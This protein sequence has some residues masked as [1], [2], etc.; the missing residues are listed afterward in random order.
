MVRANGGF[1]DRG[2]L[3]IANE[4]GPELVGRIG[5]QSAVANQNQIIEGI[6][7]GV[8]SAILETSFSSGKDQNINLYLDSQLVAKKV[9]KYHNDTV[10]QTGLSPLML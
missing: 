6:K 3:F 9:I 4:A 1:V 10:R 5:T 2:Q 7:Q 8:M